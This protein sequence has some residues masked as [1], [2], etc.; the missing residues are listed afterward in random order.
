ME[1]VLRDEYTMRSVRLDLFSSAK[2]MEDVQTNRL[3]VGEVASLM[4]LKSVE[5][6]VEGMDVTLT[7]L[8]G[9]DV[10]TTEELSEDFARIKDTLLSGKVYQLFQ[11]S[12]GSVPDIS[13]LTS[14]IAT[15]WAPAVLKTYDI[16]GIRKGARPVF[17]NTINDNAVEIVWQELVKEFDTQTVG[18]LIIEITDTSMTAT[19]AAA[20]PNGKISSRPLP[21]ENVL[22]RRLSDAASQAIDK[23]LA[24]KVCITNTIIGFKIIYKMFLTNLLFFIW[25]LL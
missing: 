17:V 12:F 7:S 11:T 3:S 6:M 20:T 13:R 22:I 2:M 24:N 8:K 23:G 10:V 16:A 5:D 9:M 21:G 25:S 19:R 14:W 15:K 1:P 18:K 4:A